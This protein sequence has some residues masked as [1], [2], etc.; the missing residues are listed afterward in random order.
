MNQ[1]VNPPQPG[2]VMQREA[3]RLSARALV[4]S[5][6]VRLSVDIDGNRRVAAVQFPPMEPSLTQSEAHLTAAG[7]AVVFGQMCLAGQVDLAFPIH[8]EALHLFGSLAQLLYDAHAYT[9]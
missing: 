7:M 5:L 2:H 6:A 3:L 1:D 9:Q 4:N 8:E